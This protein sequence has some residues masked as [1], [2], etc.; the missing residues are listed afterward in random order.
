MF[1]IM[2]VRDL[3]WLLLAGPV[4]AI[5]FYFLSAVQ[6]M[7]I[8]AGLYV[9]TV[10]FVIH[11]LFTPAFISAGALGMSTFASMKHAFEFVRRRHIFFVVIYA[12]F[13]VVWALNVIPFVQFVTLFFAYPLL[14]ASMI[15]M[16]E[17]SMK[18]NRSGKGEK[19][20][21]DS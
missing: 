20:D 3:L 12:L 4:L 5:Y 13:A 18:E 11:M 14:Y 2:V 7:D 8:L 19:D 21:D 6:Y 1:G 16:L 17:D 15:I 10:T 9:L